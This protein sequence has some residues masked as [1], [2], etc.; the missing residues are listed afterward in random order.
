MEPEGELVAAL[1]AAVP[2][3]RLRGRNATKADVLLYELP[4]RRLAVKDYT[5]RPVWIRNTLGRWLIRRE[6]AAYRAAAGIPEIPVLLGRLG[7]FAF[8]T[9]WVEA[10]PLSGLRDERLPAT[11]FDRLDAALAALHGRGI[12]LGDLHHRDVLVGDG[13]RVTVVDFATAWLAPPSAGRLRRAVFR[14]LAA[15]DRLAAV[16]LRARFTGVAEEAA[17]AGADPDALR[18]WRRARRWKRLWDRLRP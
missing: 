5:A 9:A 8:A 7:P 15:Q 10:R 17:L 1:R 12:A 11:L 16:R 14:R 2:K 4:G 3:L 18:R 13:G 6:L